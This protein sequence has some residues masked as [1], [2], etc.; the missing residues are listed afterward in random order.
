MRRQVHYAALDGMR[1]VVALSV[2]FYHL[3]HWLDIPLLATNA[4]LAVDF[5]FCLSGFVLT[6]AYAERLDRGMR[7]GPFM[8]L[9]LLRLMPLMALATLVSAVFVALRSA[10]KSEPVTPAEIAVATALGLLDIPYFNASS[11][12]GGPQI[13]PLNGPQYTLFLEVFVNAFW[14]LSRHFRTP[15]FA[16]LVAGT[17]LLGVAWP[18]AFGGDVAESFLAGFPRVFAAFYLGVLA[19]Y[20]DRRLGDVAPRKLLF[21]GCSV[22]T[23]AMFYCPMEAP[24]WMDICWIGLFAPLIVFAGAGVALGRRSRAVAKLLG[25]LSY[26][27]YILHYPLFCWVNGAFQWAF[28]SKSAG[29]ESVL[30]VVT[31]LSASWVALR[32]FDEPLR[33]RMRPTSPG[34]VLG[35]PRAAR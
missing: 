3:G 19:Y 34:A 30:L 9:R 5:F 4:G 15:K 23:L 20:L 12:L 1:G 16:M 33:T 27:L 25:E 8:Q 24:F 29:A 13:F 2:L 6:F 14:A 21:G 22:L 28:G 7:F 32:Y 18:G 26:P 11:A 17:A 10:V 35:P 31:A